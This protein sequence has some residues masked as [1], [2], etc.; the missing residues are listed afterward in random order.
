MCQDYLINALAV[1]HTV[2]TYMS[3]SLGGRSLRL[4]L[5]IT[6]VCLTLHVG[7]P[8]DGDPAVYLFRSQLPAVSLR[9]S[10]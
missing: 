2:L 8:E 5:F 10:G 4:E 3:L 1:S 7:A 6:C 9:F